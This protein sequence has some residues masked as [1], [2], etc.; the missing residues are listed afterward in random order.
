MHHVCG[1]HEWNE[2]QCSHGPLTEI[3]GGKE[4]LEMDSKAA[5]ELK[6]IVLDREWLKSLE[7]YVFFRYGSNI[8]MRY[9]RVPYLI[10]HDCGDQYSDLVVHFFFPFFNVNCP[11]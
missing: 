7:F 10:L 6:K 11:L 9:K 8:I 5:K 2:G 1:E 3:E 4:Y